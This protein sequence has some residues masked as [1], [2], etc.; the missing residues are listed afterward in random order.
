M[1][2]E[3][4]IS[5]LGALA[6]VLGGG[7]GLWALFRTRGLAELDERVRATEAELTPLLLRKEKRAALAEAT[8]DF[9]AKLVKTGASS[10]RAVIANKGLGDARDVDIKVLDDGPVIR[11]NEMFPVKVIESGDSVELPAVIG[12]G[13]PS[14]VQFLVTWSDDAQPNA[15]KELTAHL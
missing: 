3:Q 15:S 5:A 9:S 4:I 6:G 12:L 7:A 2:V 11:P 8:A 10:W 14:K 13:K 1:T